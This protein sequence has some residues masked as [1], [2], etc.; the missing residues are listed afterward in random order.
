MAKALSEAVQRFID[1]VPEDRR[2]Q[3]DLLHALILELYPEAEVVISYQVPTYKAK[4]GWVALGYWK[5]GVS[6]YTN[7]PRH[8]AP[9][10]AKHPA[11][12]TNKASINFKSSEAI[13]V[14]DLK[15][16]ITHAVEQTK[17]S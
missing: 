1:A 13:P 5:G 2:S 4:S 17:R 15:Q 16:V 14:G 11:I 7:N 3:F 9:F 6:V 10:K 12:K 8:I